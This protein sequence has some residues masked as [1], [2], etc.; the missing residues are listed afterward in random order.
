MSPIKHVRVHLTLAQKKKLLEDSLKSGF[1]AVK[2]A[3][4]MELAYQP[5]IRFWVSLYTINWLD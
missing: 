5:S 1:D 4:T 3:K 2:A